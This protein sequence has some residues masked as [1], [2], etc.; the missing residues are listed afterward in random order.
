MRIAF[1]LG[2]DCDGYVVSDGELKRT[3]FHR[4]RVWYLSDKE[5]ETTDSII[6]LVKEKLQKEIYVNLQNQNYHNAFM[7]NT[8]GIIYDYTSICLIK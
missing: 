1:Q 2:F 8:M 4:K 3:N 5:I 7:V 6:L